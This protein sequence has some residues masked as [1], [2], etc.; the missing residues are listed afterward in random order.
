[1]GTSPGYIDTYYTRTLTLDQPYPAL[2]QDISCDVCVVGG[3][4]AGI[5]TA[6]GLVERGQNNV[7]VIDQ[8]RIGWGASS[9]NGG[10]VAKGYSAGEDTLVD[11]V[12]LDHARQLV[13]LTKA[14]RQ[15]IRERIDQYSIDCGPL[16]PGVLTVSW[17]NP[18]S[19]FADK[20]AQMNRDFDVGLEYWPVERVRAHCKTQR[21]FDGMYSPHDFQF[22]SLRYIQGLAA[23]IV[24]KGAHI[25]EN[26]PALS[27]KADGKGW[28]VQTPQ[29]LIRTQKV[30][31]CCSI[32]AQGLNKRL[33]NAA[34]PVKTFVM[35]TDAVSEAD[36]ADSINTAHAIYDTRFASD[37]YRVL[38]DRRIMWGGRVQLWGS[39]HN[40]AQ[41][42]F[43]DMLKVYPQLAGKTKPDIAWSGLMCY[44]PHK[45]PQIGELAPGYWYNMGYGGHGLVPTTVGG[46]AIAQ[47]LLGPDQTYQ[48][49]APFGLSYA[50]GHMGRYVAQM[51]YWWWRIRDGL[52]TTPALSGAE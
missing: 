18:Q 44:A 7:V 32:Y 49:F 9:R 33:E 28:I 26:S 37:Y 47:A 51:V 14:A 17:E 27:I 21:Y 34:F 22:H 3:G 5:N 6:F 42:M 50:G 30:V 43:N 31:V 11:K 19:G 24:Q 48:L 1:M 4:L 40:L 20:I 23:L 13:N 29:G 12:G 52:S 36:L 46:E 41:T 16:T 2:Q 39:P 10:F 15:M 25:F 8:H 38:P 45:M 35:I